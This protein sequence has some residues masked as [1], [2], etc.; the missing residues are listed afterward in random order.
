MSTTH[1]GD[2]RVEGEQAAQRTS[3][4]A[5]SAAARAVQAQA[6]ATQ[7]TNEATTAELAD[8]IPPGQRTGA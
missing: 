5:K 1:S 3:D 7:A 6:K 2:P 8:S 4:E